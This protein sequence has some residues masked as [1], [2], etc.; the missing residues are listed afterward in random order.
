MNPPAV[1]VS[2]GASPHS[3]TTPPSVLTPSSHSSPFADPDYGRE[4]EHPGH[5][6]AST[7][8]WPLEETQRPL[9]G[10]VAFLSMAASAAVLAF[11]PAPPALPDWLHGVWEIRGVLPLLHGFAAML[12]V[13]VLV[14][15]THRRHFDFQLHRA[16]DGAA[17]GRIAERCAALFFCLVLA[18]LLYHTLYPLAYR[19]FHGEFFEHGFFKPFFYVFAPAVFVLS[20][21]CFWLVEKF[22]RDGGPCD[23][24]LVLARCA[25]R[26]ILPSSATDAWA[27]VCNLHVRN[28]FLG[29]LVKFFYVP[30]MFTWCTSG[31]EN[32]WAPLAYPF[33]GWNSPEDIAANVFIINTV[34]LMFMIAAEVSVA[35][36]GYLTSL[37]LLDSQ[38]T[39]AEPTL[40]GWMMALACYPPFNAVLGYISVGGRDLWPERVCRDLPVFSM[41][42]GICSILLMGVYS[43]ATFCFGF[44]FSNLTNRGIVCCGP[45]RYVRHPAY[46]CKNTAWWIACVPYMLY[47][48]SSIPLCIFGL[49]V[50]NAIYGL[51][52]WTEERH[53]MR[54]P[55]YREYCEKVP[56]RFIPGVW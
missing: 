2:P 36:V 4:G 3:V 53:L 43:W 41:V 32:D 20:I 48:P 25:R 7:P 6:I 45:Y 52:A 28:L 15:R 50:T 1:A 5:V 31:W 40:F 54:E 44:R 38:V 14:H 19:S 55:H 42:A 21:P 56:W 9:T 11:M 49:L 47:R 16:L 30:L 33:H 34:L 39:T 29:L 22:A 10:L 12:V 51:R 37:R 23:E 26:V 35:L 24:F 17:Y 46:I 27:A 18:G 8:T 13:E